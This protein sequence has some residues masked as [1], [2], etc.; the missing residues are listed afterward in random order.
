M[1]GVNPPLLPATAPIAPN[2]DWKEALINEPSGSPCMD[3]THLLLTSYEP[4]RTRSE[5]A[6]EVTSVNDHN[7]IDLESFLLGTHDPFS[8]VLTCVWRGVEGGG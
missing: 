5:N 8:W 6:E 2:E 1:N 4:H 7:C 3:G